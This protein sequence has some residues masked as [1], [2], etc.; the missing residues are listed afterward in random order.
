MVPALMASE[1]GASPVEK[2][3]EMK[4]CQVEVAK[5]AANHAY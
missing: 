4:C 5:G 2:V 1:N 3:Q